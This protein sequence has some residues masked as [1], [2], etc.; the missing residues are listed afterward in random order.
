MSVSFSYVTDT[1]MLPWPLCFVILLAAMVLLQHTRII[2]VSVYKIL[3]YEYTTD[4]VGLLPNASVESKQ[5]ISQQQALPSEHRI[6][7][8]DSLE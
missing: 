6:R 1:L 4:S 2:L 5:L 7:K 3:S 8:Y